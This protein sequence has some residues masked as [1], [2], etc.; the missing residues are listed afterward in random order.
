MMGGKIVQIGT[1]AE[2]MNHPADEDIAAFV[3]IETILEGRVLKSERGITVV[4][5]S[6]S[7]IETAMDAAPGE[8]VILC[9]RP[10]N[11]TLATGPSIN[12]TSARNAF[13]G[14]VQRI[15]P[16]GLFYKVHLDCGFPLVSYVTKPALEDL[17]I[18]EGSDITASFKAT[19]IHV[20]RRR[21]PPL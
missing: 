7:E 6:G 18:G 19:A 12:P 8:A 13:P 9:I 5:V 21:E 15:L 14:K 4:S 10:E 1:S 2:V 3:G 20:I 16:A 11:V 17:R